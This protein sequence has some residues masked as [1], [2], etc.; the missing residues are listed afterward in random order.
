MKSRSRRGKRVDK[1]F[2]FHEWKEGWAKYA[3]RYLQL[4]AR[5]GGVGTYLAKIGV[6][7]TP[8][9]WWCGQAKQFVEHLYIK[10]WWWR[11]ERRK[12]TSSLCKE[13]ISWQG[14]TE[15]KKIAELLANE[16]AM[17]LL[18]GFLISTEVGGREGAKERELE[19]M[20]RDDW[21][22]EELL[23]AWDRQ[24]GFRRGNPPNVADYTRRDSVEINK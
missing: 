14:W 23:G 4:K 1:V 6:I 17:G 24:V 5:H 8:K 15:R 2:T 10:C 7:E 21:I 12:L 22:G 20:Q 18:L 11:K 13:G 3:S 19:W 9:C 16:K